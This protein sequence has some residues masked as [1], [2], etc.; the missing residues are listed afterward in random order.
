MP[1]SII[2]QPTYWA[3]ETR[4]LSTVMLKSLESLEGLI[5]YLEQAHGRRPLFVALNVV[6]HATSI[7]TDVVIPDHEQHY[8]C[9]C[10]RYNDFSL[11]VDNSIKSTLES[12]KYVLTNHKTTTFQYSWITLSRT[13]AYLQL[14]TNYVRWTHFLWWPCKPT[15][16]T[17]S[18][19][20][21]WSI[22]KASICDPNV[23]TKISNWKLSERNCQEVG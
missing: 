18:V 22:S 10:L 2:T 20:R 1:Y 5:V 21:L 16:R 19:N 23:I 12:I 6:H 13:L 7:Q 9:C 15:L 4:Y 11:D 17:I 8:C 3:A 14:L